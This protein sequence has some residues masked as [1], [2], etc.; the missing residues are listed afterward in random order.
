MS[1]ETSHQR[2]PQALPPPDIPSVLLLSLLWYRVS[3]VSVQMPHGLRNIY[4]RCAFFSVSSICLN[5]SKISQ[6]IGDENR[7]LLSKFTRQ[8]HLKRYVRKCN[9]VD[10]SVKVS[11]TLKC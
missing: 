11:V 1:K 10:S 4:L 8:I 6:K 9:C 7:D 3:G 5:R 2:Q